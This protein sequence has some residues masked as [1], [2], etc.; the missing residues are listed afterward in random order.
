M[1]HSDTS[2]PPPRC[3]MFLHCKT[4]GGGDLPI[5]SRNRTHPHPLTALCDEGARLYTSAL[6]K[7]RITRSEASAAPC[8]LGFALLQPDP[9]DS[10]WLRPVPP[11][12]ALAQRL[13][14]IE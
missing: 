5:T 6:S 8:L 12:V 2:R 11:S 10:N 13:H 9:D 1:S 7:G 4:L 14:P 3:I